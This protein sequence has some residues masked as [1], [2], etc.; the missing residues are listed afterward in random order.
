MRLPNEKLKTQ[1]REEIIGVAAELFAKKNYHQVLMDE[2]AVCAGI[3]K[4]TLY[5]YF[6]NKEDLYISII[7][8]RLNALLTLLQERVDTKQTPLINLRRVIVHIYSFMTKY[9]HFFQIWYREKL[10]FDRQIHQEIHKL[11]R[12]IK[13][14]LQRALERGYEDGILREHQPQ[15]VADIVLGV[16]DAAVLRSMKLSREEQSRERIRVYEFVLDALG[17]EKAWEMHRAGE[18]EPSEGESQFA[19]N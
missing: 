16:I 18:D 7:T 15:F 1:R 19:A 11:Y 2:V 13:Q 3:A 17:T 14:V 8:D 4:G 5:N 6:S 10:N 12:Q 9:P